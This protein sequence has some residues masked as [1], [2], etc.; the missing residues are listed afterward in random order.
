MQ[1]P[2]EHVGG[3]TQ[4]FGQQVELTKEAAVEY[5]LR[6]RAIIKV[7]NEVCRAGRNRIVTTAR[8]M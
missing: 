7:G 1:E 4:G 2:A 5:Q 6:R 3:R 8:G